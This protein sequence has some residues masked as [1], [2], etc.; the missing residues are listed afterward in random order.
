MSDKC[1]L[2]FRGQFHKG[3]EANFMS[4]EELGG[5][6]DWQMEKLVMNI[7]GGDCG[8]M[9][10]GMGCLCHSISFV[11]HLKHSLL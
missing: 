9:G 2:V 3:K 4:H 1:L 5:D 7:F 10:V 6:I 11:M 8:W